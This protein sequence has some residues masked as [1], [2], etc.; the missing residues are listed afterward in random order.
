MRVVP[1]LDDQGKVAGYAAGSDAETRKLASM[2]WSPNANPG[3]AFD[4]L[5]A[6]MK[7]TLQNERAAAEQDGVMVD[8]NVFSTDPGSQT[9]YVGILVYVSQAPSY[10]GTWKSHNNGFVTL[11][12]AGVTRLCHAVMA[13]IEACFAWE[14]DVLALIDAAQTVDELLTIDLDSG[15]PIGQGLA[16]S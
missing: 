6:K 11:D 5:K 10:S 14:R 1:L 12:A 13:Y 3:S 7:L 2:R 16:S 8:G 9:K 15:K 4:A